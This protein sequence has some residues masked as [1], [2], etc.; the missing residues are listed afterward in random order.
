VIEEIRQLFAHTAW[1]D[2]RLVEALNAQAA[3]PA[4][5]VTELA[6]ILGADEIWLSRLEGRPAQVPVWPTMTAAA[7]Q[8]LSAMVHEGYHRYLAG[9]DDGKIRQVVSYTNSAGKA[10][11][12][13]VQD[14]LLH[15]ALHA[16]YHRGK[17]N[18]LLR[19][20]SLEP[21]AADYIAFIRGAP[22]AITPPR[23]APA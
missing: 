21:A 4:A 19:Q 7:L 14:I 15:V 22:A 20:A 2:A 3:P 1:A 5:A 18:L 8:G 11:E 13:T 6:H 9:L 16:Q 23:Q 12:N 10:F 17:V